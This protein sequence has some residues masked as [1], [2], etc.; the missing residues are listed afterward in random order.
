MGLLHV[1]DTIVEIMHHDYAGFED[2]KG[3]DRPE[4]FREKVKGL[5]AQNPQDRLFFEEIVN[6]Y[7]L[8]FKDDHNSLR[9]VKSDAPPLSVGFRVR[10]FED[11]LYVEKTDQETRIAPGTRIISLDGLTVDEAAEKYRRYLKTDIAEREWWENILLK[12]EV[13][14]IVTSGGEERTLKLKK[15]DDPRKPS[16]YQYENIE[17]ISVFR[18]ND[19]S[20]LEQME[21]L[22]TEHQDDIQTSHQWIVDVREC[23]GG[24]DSVYMPLLN[25]IFPPN[26][27]LK[28]ESMLHLVTERNYRNRMKTFEKF[29]TTGGAFIEAFI[30]QMETN[31]GKGFVSFDFSEFQEENPVVGSTNPAQVILLIDKFCGSSG[32]SFVI[33]ARQSPKVTLVGRPTRGVLDYSNQAVEHFEEEGYDF[34]YATSRMGW[35]D[36]G[37]GIDFK[38]IAPDKHIPWTP[39]HLIQDVDLK[40]AL[41]MLKS[42]KTN[43]L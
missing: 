14:R 24:A 40:I 30:K 6:D 17:G 10:H 2:K 9:S 41:D 37:E 38:G 31:R 16:H 1:F 42:A 8:D 19:F 20:D 43:K 7:L 3:W 27:V 4:Y 29:N 25:G 32:E 35:L 26:P 11:S 28:D 15:Y 13:V 21:R 33:D 34:Y 23:R 22:L 18:F 39:E 5:H 12:S 36:R